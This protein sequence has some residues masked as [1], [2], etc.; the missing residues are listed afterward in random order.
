MQDDLPRLS[1]NSAYLIVEN[2]GHHIQ[3][4]RPDVVVAAVNEVVASV[5]QQRPLNRQAIA[6]K[7][8]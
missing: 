3:L 7:S 2:A 1:S 4:D 8:D 5:R 6:A